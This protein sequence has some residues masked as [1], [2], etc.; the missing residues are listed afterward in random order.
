M[1]L[2]ILIP[3]FNA[4]NHIIN[5]L[6]SIVNQAIHSEDYEVII[7]ND[8]STDRSSQLISDFVK[9][10]PNM[11]LIDQKNKGN[12]ATRNRLFELA[13]GTYVYCLD[14]DDYLI[15]KALKRGLDF[16]MQNQM[17][18]V[19]FKSKQTLISDEENLP[20][21]EFEDDTTISTGV[22]YLMEK[23]LPY[24]EV[25]WYL[26][27]RKLLKDFEISLD[28]MTMADVIFT[29]KVVLSSQRMSVLPFQVHWY[30]Q[31][32]VSV[33]R[34]KGSISEHKLRLADA[35]YE[36]VLGLNDL[37]EKPEKFI[38]AKNTE[39]KKD[40]ILK[41]DYYSFFMIIKWLRFEDNSQKIR[42]S[43]NILEQKSIYPFESHVQIHK[44]PYFFEK[45]I[46]SAIN[47]KKIVFL[48]IRFIS[49]FKP[50]K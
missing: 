18:F 12:A 21:K 7:I 35:T 6:Q 23:P 45:I 16:A 22:E 2:S 40:L 30:F 39:V 46:N 20:S 33:M 11:L 49:I 9:D 8:G 14:A 43:I 4:E 1:Y 13:K 41:R 25:W 48:F 34:T 50:R 24:V 29:Y 28:N 27:A 5:C 42:D 44:I 15:P 32:P 26:V 31:S 19:G 3:V 10:K 37:I 17:D 36:M 38:L 47:N